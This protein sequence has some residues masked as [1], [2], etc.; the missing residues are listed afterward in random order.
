MTADDLARI[1]AARFLLLTHLPACAEKDAV[2]WEL[3]S[4]L[5]VLD[6]PTIRRCARCGLGFEVSADERA[7]IEQHGWKLPNCCASCRQQKKREKAMRA[8]L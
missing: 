1:K 5:A 6:D 7:Y 8:A 3:D 2:L 4:F